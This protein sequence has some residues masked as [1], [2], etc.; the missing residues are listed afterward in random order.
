MRTSISNLKGACAP[1]ASEYSRFLS[2]TMKKLVKHLIAISTLQTLDQ[3]ILEP[4]WSKGP[5][6]TPS[7]VDFEKT[8]DEQEKE[9]ICK[10]EN[11]YE[12]EIDFDFSEDNIY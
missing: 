9:E 7:L 2:S 12:N 6:L 11:E 3:G 5:I 8:K 1:D 4:I 10:E